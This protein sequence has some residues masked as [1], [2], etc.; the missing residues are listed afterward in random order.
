[1][2]TLLYVSN[3]V[4]VADLSMLE[5]LFTT[6]G[7]VKAQHL[8]LI[9]ESG[10]RTEFGVF[11]MSTEQQAFDCV[12]RFNGQTINGKQL[13]IVSERPKTRKRAKLK[14]NKRLFHRGN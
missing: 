10:H 5:D 7:D 13:A 9:P 6:V 14:S 11:E 4:E 3:V 1:M 2:R 12:E 8:E